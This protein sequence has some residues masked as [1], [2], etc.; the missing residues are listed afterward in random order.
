M[1]LVEKYIL[2]HK[3]GSQEQKQVNVNVKDSRLNKNRIAAKNERLQDSICATIDNNTN[4]KIKANYK[5]I[6]AAKQKAYRKA[7]RLN[8]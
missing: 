5:A 3:T 2:N 4:N 6:R 7:K 1:Q 8:K